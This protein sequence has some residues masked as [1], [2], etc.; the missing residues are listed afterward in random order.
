M[1]TNKEDLSQLNKVPIGAT[2]CL[3]TSAK[4]KYAGVVAAI[5]SVENTITLQDVRFGG[6][7][8][9]ENDNSTTQTTE[10]KEPAVGTLFECVTFWMSNVIKLSVTSQPEPKKELPD[11]AVKAVE[12]NS[13]IKKPVVS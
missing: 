6:M 8:G 1:E 4:Y 11:N 10:S 2:V 3:V 9:R 5:N 13:P 12:V 7:D